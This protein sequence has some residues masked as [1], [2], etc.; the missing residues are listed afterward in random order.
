VAGSLLALTLTAG[1]GAAPS[2]HIPWN[3]D[4]AW[5]PDG[6]RIAH[7][8]HRL[9]NTDIYVMDVNGKH[10]QRLTT[11]PSDDYRPAWSPDGRRIAFTSERDDS[12]E[13]SVMN[14]DGLRPDTAHAERGRQLV[15]ELVAERNHARVHE[16]PRRRGPDLHDPRERFRRT[17]RDARPRL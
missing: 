8:G 10:R 17:A 13:I 6:S 12:A 3:S 4:P 14:A 16:R 15:A 2:D 1:G 11:N 5:S 9:H 7:T